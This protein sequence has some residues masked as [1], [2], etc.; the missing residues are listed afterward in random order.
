VNWLNFYLTCFAVGGGFSLLALF[1]G[2]F[3]APHL[4]LH[5]HAGGGGHAGGGRGGA[6]FNMGTIA[7]FLLWFGACGY[8]ITRFETWWFIWG[9][10]LAM[11]FGLVGASL[12]FWFIARVLL[13]NDVPLD[14]ADYEMI[15]VLGQVTSPIREGGGTGEMTYSQQGRRCAT[16]VRSEDGRAVAKGTEVIVTRYEKGIAYVQGFDELSQE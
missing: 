6:V 15:G 16:P 12:V 14:P 13:R 9:L 10:L 4:H 7:A 2:T 5:L 11:L 3:H 8:F 1:G